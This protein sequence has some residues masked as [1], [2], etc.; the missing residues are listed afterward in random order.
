MLITKSPRRLRARR[1]Q[2]C[3]A[4]ILA[5]IDAA[6]ERRSLAALPGGR[7]GRSQV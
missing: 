4:E 6:I 5:R 2:R 1:R 7:R 3:K